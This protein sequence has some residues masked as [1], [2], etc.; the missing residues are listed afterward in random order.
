MERRKKLIRNKTSKKRKRRKKESEKIRRI[1]IK[2]H[3][4]NGVGL[5]G[6]ILLRLTDMRGDL[7]QCNYC[8]VALR[9]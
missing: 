5:D 7:W 6:Y 1:G 3:Q 8:S 4:S 9:P 2:K